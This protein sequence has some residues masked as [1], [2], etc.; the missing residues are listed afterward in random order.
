M[1]QVTN[2]QLWKA[3]LGIEGSTYQTA[4]NRLRN[5]FVD[6]REKV[7]TLASEISRNLPEYTVHDIT[8]IDALWEMADC[9]LGLDYKLNPV[10]AYIL[11]G[12]FLLHDLGMSLSAYPEG[13]TEIE[14]QEL[15]K[16]TAYYEAK[17][18][19]ITE[20]DSVKF[21]ELPESIKSN[22]LSTVLRKLHAATAERIATTSWKSKSDKSQIFLIDNVEIR[23]SFG[24]TIGKIAHSHW[25]NISRIESEFGRVLGAP[26]W[27]P[28]EWTIDPLKIASILR[29]ADAAHID[30]RRAP[31]FLRA[32]RSLNPSSDYHWSFQEKLQ[33]PYLSEDCLF[34]TSGYAFS[35]EDAPSWWL[36]FDALN[37]IDK[38]LRETDALL[39]DRQ[40][41]RFRA[42][43][44]FGVESPERLS[45]LIQTDG[46]HPI[47]AFI[48]IGDLPKIIRTL[49]GEELY[50]RNYTVPIR[51]MIQ[52]SSDAIRARIMLEKRDENWGKIF[53][54]YTEKE[55][56]KCIEVRDNGIGMSI[57]GIKNFLFEFRSSYWD[58]DLL[59]EEH[60]SLAGQKL[61]QTGKY[62][63]G[64]FSLF[65]LGN[66]IEIITRK[67]NASQKETYV[68]EFY[69]GL[70]TRPII[71]QAT[72]NEQLI[73]GGTQIRV[74]LDAEINLL[75]SYRDEKVS[76]QKIVASIAPALDCFISIKENDIKHDYPPNYWLT[77]S[78]SDFINWLKLVR[79]DDY[80]EY[81]KSVLPKFYDNAANNL[82]FLKNEDGEFLGR[83]FL[84]LPSMS[85]NEKNPGMQG[86]ISV[87]G[88]AESSTSGLSG[89][90]KGRTN[91]AAR[92][93]ADL[94]VPKDIL[95]AWAS[96]QSQLAN[97]LY[98]DKGLLLDIAQCVRILKGNANDL[99]IVCSN[100]RYYSIVEFREVVKEKN[101]LII[102]SNFDL[103]YTFRDYK[104]IE[105]YENVFFSGISGVPSLVNIKGPGSWGG[106]SDKNWLYNNTCLGYIIDIISEEWTIDLKEL[107]SLVNQ[108]KLRKTISIGAI[109]GNIIN[110]YAYCFKRSKKSP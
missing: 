31:V 94:I 44:V 34:Y 3:T 15:W 97:N 9:I 79:G 4:I 91:K 87:G 48:H 64:F 43:R 108:Q 24:R 50:G 28:R 51:E 61:N 85:S 49:G 67:S 93:S 80:L 33:K 59:L 99:P 65:M 19:G 74:T 66:E 36:C 18:N 72:S 23:Q 10:E 39:A 17:K 63:I 29:T 20:L 78:N 84:S 53:I 30:S 76:F 75:R 103:K 47:D 73:E 57:E 101:D 13:I 95:S 16:S 35:S 1:D 109:G 54:S 62:G 6:F 52:N 27:C 96:E 26:A 46:W 107:L 104:D 2:T 42:K 38:E 14:T 69:D 105:I 11:G 25:W 21:S 40:L 86:V 22:V 55:N 89:I 70:H 45:S 110:D 83:A 32:L 58:S 82:T 12:A 60:P 88:L 68:V 7:T 92:D 37:L 5:S 81:D 8:H 71:R 106:V 56:K 102:A 98:E 77:C 100:T 90:F 41:Q